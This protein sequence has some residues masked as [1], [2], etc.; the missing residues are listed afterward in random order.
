MA[1]IN[2]D[3]AGAVERYRSLLSSDENPPDIWLNLGVVYA[4]SGRIDAAREAWETALRYVP[5]HV[6]AR[7]FFSNS[8]SRTSGAAVQI[9]WPRKDGSD[10]LKL[11][12]NESTFLSRV[13]CRYAHSSSTG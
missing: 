3:V 5:K 10:A 12:G 13:S 8:S 2:G 6:G 9:T 11:S 1:L 4:A 7:A